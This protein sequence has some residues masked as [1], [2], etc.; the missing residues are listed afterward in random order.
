MRYLNILR[1]ASLLI[2]II[3][4]ISFR[5]YKS[6]IGRHYILE[7][8]RGKYFIKG[9]KKYLTVPVI[10]FNNTNDTL[11]YL[12]MTCSYQQFYLLDS[13]MLK[14]DEWNCN[15][16]IPVTLSLA[17]HMRSSVE[18]KFMFVNSYKLPIKY[19]VGMELVKDEKNNSINLLLHKKVDSI[20]IW[21]NTLKWNRP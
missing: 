14:W 19:R 8:K 3:T 20:I 7:I 16:N 21:S 18:L 10:L 2:I 15:K 17:P 12:S 11:R 9:T 13:K 1:Y 6:N 4:N 5:Y